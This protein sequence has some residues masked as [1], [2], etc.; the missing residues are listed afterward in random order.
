MSVWTKCLLLFS[1][2][3]LDAQLTLVWVRGGWATEGNGL[4]AYLLELGDAHFLLTKL[5]VGA[6][7]ACVLY[8]WSHVALARR[9]LKL[10]LGLYV[11]LMFV[12]TATALSALGAAP[13]TVVAY[14]KSLS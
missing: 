6:F 13:E 12:H 2:N 9:G 7:V 3:W 14:V 11:V 5:A 1:L 10:V 8:R 4:M